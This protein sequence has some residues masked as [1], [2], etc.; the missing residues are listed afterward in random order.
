MEAVIMCSV[1]VLCDISDLER[2]AFNRACQRHG[3]PSILNT[4]D[5][6]RL[7]STTTMLE[8]LN[9]LPCSRTQ[10][11]ALIA[12]YLEILNDEV[13][14]ATLTPYKAASSAVLGGNRFGRQKG[15][16]SDYPLHTTNMVRSATFLTNAS[17]LGQLSAVSDPSQPETTA[18][19]LTTCAA[20]LGVAHHDTEVLVAYRRDFLAAQSIGMSPRFI[21]GFRS[22][23]RTKSERHTQSVEIHMRSSIRGTPIAANAAMSA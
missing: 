11:G 5:H 3:V 2:T 23:A 9:R 8:F 20:S 13:W 15:F 17:R 22:I 14:T 6:A 12:S 21:G 16:V 19:G 18:A 10:R 7:L 1:H 4:R